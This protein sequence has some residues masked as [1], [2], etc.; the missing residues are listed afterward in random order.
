M[1]KASKSVFSGVCAWGSGANIPSCLVNN[2]FQAECVLEIQTE[3]LNC[4]LL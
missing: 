3:R 2:E 4:A 1:L